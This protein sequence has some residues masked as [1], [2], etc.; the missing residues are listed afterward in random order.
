MSRA[1][2]LVLSRLEG[3]TRRGDKDMATCP[4]HE[5]I[6]KSLSV[7]LGE[8]QRVVAGKAE[9]VVVLPALLE[10]LPEVEHAALRG[11]IRK[12]KIT[13]LIPFNLRIVLNPGVLEQ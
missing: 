1:I 9:Q 13:G 5:D 11:A 6:H 10:A 7:D 12:D 2:E 8:D 4:S 3:V